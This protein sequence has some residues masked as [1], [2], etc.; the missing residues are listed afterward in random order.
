MDENASVQNKLNNIENYIND[1]ENIEKEN[2]EL[3]EN[4]ENLNQDFNLIKNDKEKNENLY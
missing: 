2:K 1:L 4:L 3:K